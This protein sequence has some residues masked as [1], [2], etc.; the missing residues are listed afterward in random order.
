M[1]NNWANTEISAGFY[2][3]FFFFFTFD[4]NNVKIFSDLSI[5]PKE[6]NE[7]ILNLERVLVEREN[8]PAEFVDNELMGGSVFLVQPQFKRLVK[9]S[10]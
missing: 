8:C 4:K 2:S 10:T 5:C 3:L 7:H 6:V 1:I 9:G